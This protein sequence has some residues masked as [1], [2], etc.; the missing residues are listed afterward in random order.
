[1][2]LVRTAS[3]TG[4]TF[5]S[6]A[7]SVQVQVHLIDT[8]VGEV[9]EQGMAMWR[10]LAARELDL[11]SE[12]PLRVDLLRFGP[13][14]H[15]LMLT[16]HHMVWDAWS[17]GIFWK[18]LWTCYGH[19]DVAA[20]LL[21]SPLRTT[22]AEIAA[23]QHADGSVLT[24]QQL[25]YWS[26]V[27]GDVDMPW[28]MGDDIE[29]LPQV[30]DR[31][32]GNRMVAAEPDATFTRRLGEFARAARVTT[33]SALTT[34]CLLALGQALGVDSV[35][36]CY[37]HHGRD[38]PQEW[39]LI[40]MFCRRFPVRADL[41]P[42]KQLGE[43]ARQ[44]QRGLADGAG[45]SRSPF[46]LP[47]LARALH[48]EAA[49]LG[50]SPITINMVPGTM[51]GAGL[52]HGVGASLFAEPLQTGELGPEATPRYRNQLWLIATTDPKPVLYLD[53][54][55]AVVAD[56]TAEELSYRLTVI[57]G[58]TGAAAAGLPLCTLARPAEQ[59][60]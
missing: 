44:V 37:L 40:G 30:A 7:E 42:D 22:F 35:L 19:D 20:E 28:P 27:V 57:I 23:A 1:M 47:R 33:A 29:P 50:I 9:E 52:A 32:P 58:A 12:P 60:G 5:T 48:G 49:Y 11:F 36:T 6:V 4:Q 10:E 38:L 3:G 13:T 24:D 46:T 2:R 51:R 17:A 41:F 16:V 26:Q 54:D 55:R 15:I 31:H 25:A 56:A 34:V 18:Q 14:D 21:A 45:A 53:Y 59:I 8:D 39:E 43:L